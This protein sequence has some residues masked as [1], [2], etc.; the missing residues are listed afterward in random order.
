MSLADKTYINMCK[1]IIDNGW[2]YMHVGTDASTS[3]DNAK[4]TINNTYIAEMFVA[5][6]QYE[7]HSVICPVSSGDILKMTKRIHLFV[8]LE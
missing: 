5:S 2:V 4:L 7:R 3:T 8:Y 6:Q 1:E